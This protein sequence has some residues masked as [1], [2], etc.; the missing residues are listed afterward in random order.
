MAA[1]SGFGGHVNRAQLMAATLKELGDHEAAV[2]Q[3][4]L[5]VN[6]NHAT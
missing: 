4:D 5:T 3:L 2:A 6:P 1:G